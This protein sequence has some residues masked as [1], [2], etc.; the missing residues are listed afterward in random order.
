MAVVEAGQQLW[1]AATHGQRFG[2]C[3]M[4]FW[5]F[6]FG[7]VISARCQQCMPKNTYRKLKT[8]QT[9]KSTI[10]RKKMKDI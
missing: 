8:D 10:Q 6:Y 5:S 2:Y 3:V 1:A 4:P 7:S 9:K